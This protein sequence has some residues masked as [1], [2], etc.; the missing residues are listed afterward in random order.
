[1]STLPS[2]LG[3]SLFRPSTSANGGNARSEQIAE[4]VKEAGF[5]YDV[6]DR[7]SPHYPA[8]DRVRGLIE[9]TI[10][11]ER[12]PALSASLLGFYRALLDQK[13]SAHTGPRVLLCEDTALPVPLWYAR[14]LGFKTIA[15]PHNVEALIGA[16]SDVKNLAAEHAALKQA[17]AV[18]CI[19]DEDA[20]LWSNLGLDVQVLPYFPLGERRRRLAALASSRSS[21]PAAN[22]PWLLLG[23]AHHPPTREGMRT[24]LNW[25]KPTLE[26]GLTIVVAGHGTADLD[27]GN[28]PGVTL[29]GSLSDGELDA[30]LLRVRGLIVHQDRGTGALTR[31][32]EAVTAGLPV[33]ASRIAARSTS[34]LPGV[35]RYETAADLLALIYATPSRPGT[36]PNGGSLEFIARLQ[37]YARAC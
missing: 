17:D 36:V 20:W 4:L 18:F 11:G 30:L 32:P 24:V 33:L 21:P 28:L 7:E 19:S 25:L 27:C 16:S 15:L 14:R 5:S 3:W 8:S 13:L 23:T 12:W 35:V 9:K 10:H 2:I 6:I 22:A 29:A 31:I 26:T 37:A 34:L 1:M